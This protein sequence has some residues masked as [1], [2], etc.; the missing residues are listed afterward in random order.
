MEQN[1]QIQKLNS[2]RSMMETTP[3]STVTMWRYTVF[4][5]AQRLQWDIDVESLVMG[6]MLH[7]YYLY[8]ARK[9]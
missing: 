5:L 4:I 6:A 1:P 2:F 7:D 9:L 8:D 3:F